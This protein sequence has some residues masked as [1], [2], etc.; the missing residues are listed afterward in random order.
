V[1]P[2]KAPPPWQPI[3]KELR[4]RFVN[5][6]PANRLQDTGVLVHM[7]D[8]LARSL[9]QPWLPCEHNPSDDWCYVYSD[10]LSFSIINEQLPYF[11]NL[12]Y[13]AGYIATPNKVDLL[14]SW[15]IDYGTMDKQCEPPGVHDDCLPGCWVG[16]PNWCT[17]EPDSVWDCAWP[18]DLTKEMLEHH[19]NRLGRLGRRQLGAA[20]NE[21]ILSWHSFVRDL[22]DSLEAFIFTDWG[23]EPLARQA[24]DRFLEDFPGS[25]KPLLHMNLNDP[26]ALFTLVDE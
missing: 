24:R 25:K 16:A 8:Q 26:D 19:L 2:P 14:C 9:E 6:H 18:P 22:P 21:I 23:S 5:G 17:G 4:D 1:L 11:F 7:F 13:A 15:F 12:K 20:Y 10:R 3:D